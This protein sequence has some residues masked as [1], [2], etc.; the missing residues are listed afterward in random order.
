MEAERNEMLKNQI[1]EDSMKNSLASNFKINFKPY[2]QI[3]N[4][5]DNSLY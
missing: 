5:Q 2:K 4:K 3:K 1:Y